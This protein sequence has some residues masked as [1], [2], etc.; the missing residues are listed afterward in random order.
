VIAQVEKE[1]HN[2]AFQPDIVELCFQ[3]FD[4]DK[5]GKLGTDEFITGITILTSGTVEQKAELVFKCIDKNSDGAIT[6]L[7][8]RQYVTKT[9]EIAKT[10]YSKQVK[11]EG[12]NLVLRMGLNVALKVMKEALIDDILEQAF[13]ADTNHDSK[14]E[15]DEWVAAAKENNK[16]VVLFLN[17]GGLV[18]D[19]TEKLKESADEVGLIT[20]K[21]D[22]ADLLKE[23]AT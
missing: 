6:K 16:A 11:D 7:E 8:L 5:N 22:Q 15:L 9:V 4:T 21:S 10:A 23:L 14:L 2:E 20:T 17:P 13:K 19:L 18:M 3:L 1:H 12:V